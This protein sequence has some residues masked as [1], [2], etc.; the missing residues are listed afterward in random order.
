MKFATP[1]PS[2]SKRTSAHQSSYG[3]PHSKK[4]RLFSPTSP[5]T[6]DKFNTGFHPSNLFSRVSPGLSDSFDTSMDCM[7]GS[8][9]NTT[10]PVTKEICGDDV[11]MCSPPRIER[12]QL[13]D[14][15]RTPASIARSSG[16]HVVPVTQNQ[17]H[18]S[19]Q[20][21]RPTSWSRYV[22]GDHMH[23]LNCEDDAYFLFP[24]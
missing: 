3:T 13:F 20:P 4:Q 1:N 11:M 12:L 16:I 19:R 2:P 17:L 23:S 6:P 22:S 10:H 14:S 5:S 9:G 7:N 21:K 15:P 18:T 8:L 24:E